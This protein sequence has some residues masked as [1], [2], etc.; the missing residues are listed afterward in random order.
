MTEADYQ[1]SPEVVH[2]VDRAKGNLISYIEARVKGIDTELIKKAVEFAYQAHIHQYRR[3]GMPF[4]EHPFEVT[5]ILAD[6]NMDSTTLVASLLHDV[7]EDTEIG[8]KKV[9]EEFGAEVA[10][11]VEAVTKISAVQM[12]SG[13]D[14]QAE[15]FRKMLISMAKDFRVIMIKFADRLHNIRTLGYMKEEKKKKIAQETLDVYAPLAHRFGL[16]KIRW[17]LEDLSFKHINPNEYKMIVDKVIGKREER[18]AYIRNLINSMKEMLGNAGMHP[19]VYGRPK[20]FFSI[21]KKIKSR[22]C[23]FED[24]YDLFAIRIIVKEPSECY[25]VLGLVHGIWPPLQ[26]RFKDFI[27]IPKSNMYQSLHTT[28]VCPTGKPVEIQIRTEEM[29]HTAEKGIAA[30]WAYKEKADPDKTEKE[31]KWL[32][33][34]MEWQEDLTDSAEFMDFVRVDLKTDEI[35]VFTPEGDLHQFPRGATALDFAFSVHSEV[36][37]HCIGAKVDDKMVPL[38]KVLKTGCTVEIMKSDAQNP[39]RDWLRIVVTPKAKNRI[40]R[41][42]TNEE[43][44]KSIQLGKELLYREFRNQK[45]PLEKRG[46]FKPFAIEYEVGDWEALFEKIGNGEVTLGAISSFVGSLAPGK[47]KGMLNRVLMKKDKSLKNA[48]LVSGMEDTLIQFASCCRPIPGEAIIGYVGKGNGI[49]VHRA[50]CSHGVKQAKDK[51]RTI[52]VQWNADVQQFYDVFIEILAK[53]KP[54]LLYEISEVFFNCGV[55]VERA[56]I[57]TLR[58][59]VRNKFKIQVYDI[60]QLLHTFQEL[61][62]IKEIKSMIRRPTGAQIDAK[63]T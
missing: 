6:Y 10:F 1:N 23:Q 9:E 18:E 60:K 27:A 25:R 53:D 47:S 34:F 40:R 48:V 37:I 13:R 56:S 51:E 35:Y 46:N 7:V 16:A 63:G 32:N 3:S 57:I 20:H 61:K 8:K 43:N 54:G 52:P 21:F 38:D 62:Q 45:T 11:L 55:T 50:K 15:T 29:E 12:K 39:S 49:L 24:V 22:K 41:W 58:G 2:H 26:A 5:K 59:Q 33:Q 30:H 44:V 17:E 4:V 31:N 14:R 42:L 28:C 36:G 19:K